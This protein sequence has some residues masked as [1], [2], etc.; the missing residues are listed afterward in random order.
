MRRAVSKCKEPGR[1]KRF[2]YMGQEEGRTIGTWHMRRMRR[3]PPCTTGAK[4]AAAAETAA[5]KSLTPLKST[6]SKDLKERE[7]GWHQY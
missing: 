7:R 6:G 3:M 1:G 2:L 4:S 5:R